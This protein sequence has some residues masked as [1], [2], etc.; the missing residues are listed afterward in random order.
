M[1]QL[2]IAV[3]LPHGLSIGSEIRLLQYTAVSVNNPREPRISPFV[4]RFSIGS[5]IGLLDQIAVV[6]VAMGEF[7]ITVHDRGFAISTEIGTFSDLSATVESPIL[8][9]VAGIAHH[10][11]AIYAVKSLFQQIITNIV[12]PDPPG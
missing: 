5:K 2:C 8:T 4:D 9:E 3:L 11:F 12:T 10:W 7:G 6:I 1:R